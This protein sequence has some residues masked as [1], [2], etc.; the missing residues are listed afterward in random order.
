MCPTETKSVHI[1]ELALKSSP[2]SVSVQR[3]DLEAAE[4]TYRELRQSMEVQQPR[5]IEL[6][7]DK[8]TDKQIA[9]LTSEILAVQLYKKSSVGSGSKRPGFSIE[10]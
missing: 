8:M 2:V 4:Q 10:I 3:K 7:C 1:I 5:L 6:S 9:V